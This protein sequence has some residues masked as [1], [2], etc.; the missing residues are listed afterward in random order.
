LLIFVADWHRGGEN[1]IPAGGRNQEDGALESR[2]GKAAAGKAMRVATRGDQPA[3]DGSAA[4]VTGGTSAGGTT[5]GYSTATGTPT[6]S[7]P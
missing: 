1:V 3:V 4:Y 7:A 5:V 6:F 2:N